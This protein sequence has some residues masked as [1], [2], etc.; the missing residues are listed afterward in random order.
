M[1]QT[2]H[3]ISFVYPN[4]NSSKHW[5]THQQ[6]IKS[7]FLSA[8][9]KC[10]VMQLSYCR[11]E[12]SSCRTR[13]L[14]KGLRST[15]NLVTGLLPL[16]VARSSIRIPGTLGILVE[17]EGTCCSELLGISFSTVTRLLQSMWLIVHRLKE[18]SICIQHWVITRLKSEYNRAIELGNDID[19]NILL[20]QLG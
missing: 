15:R 9:R 8:A 14:Y 12:R 5:W 17:H 7:D 13:E 2:W 1:Y 4:E 20:T 19:H 10:H 16:H 11:T 3:C 18:K 6:E